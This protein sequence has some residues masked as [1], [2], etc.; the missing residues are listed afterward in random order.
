MAKHYSVGDRIES[1]GANINAKKILFETLRVEKLLDGSEINV[2]F[3]KCKRDGDATISK[4]LDPKKALINDNSKLSLGDGIS[5]NQ[6]VFFHQGIRKL[7]PTVSQYS[8]SHKA[9]YVTTKTFT[10]AEITQAYAHIQHA[11]TKK[12]L[13]K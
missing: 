10:S 1:S 6:F 8:G 7:V 12:M 4:E 3:Y 9:N 11:Q 2:V 5:G 13:K